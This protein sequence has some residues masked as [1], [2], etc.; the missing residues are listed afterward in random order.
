MSFA[1]E[2]KNEIAHYKT[3]DAACRNAELSALLWMGGEIL[4]K[5]I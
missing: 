1:E 5:A 2:V 3:W 4:F